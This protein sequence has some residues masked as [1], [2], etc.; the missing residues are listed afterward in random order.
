M[1]D[2]TAYMR[3]YNRRPEVLKRAREWYRDRWRRRHYNIS[4]EEF[5]ALAAKTDDQ[6][7]ICEVNPA[8]HVD[9]DHETGQIRGILCNACNRLIG[10][11]DDKKGMLERLVKYYGNKE[12]VDSG[13]R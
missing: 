3:E 8:T 6:C 4:Y 10:R 1:F 11:L 9:H 7:P 12:E 2:K 13:S 5:I